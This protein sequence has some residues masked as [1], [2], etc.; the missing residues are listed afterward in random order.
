[1]ISEKQ[2]VGVLEWSNLLTKLLTQGLLG[3][4]FL[5]LNKDLEKLKYATTR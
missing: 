4:S 5:N 1:M 3:N 2:T